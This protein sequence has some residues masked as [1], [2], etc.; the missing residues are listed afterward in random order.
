MTLPGLSYFNVLTHRGSIPGLDGLRGIAILL[1]LVRH[2]TVAATG[3]H[4]TFDGW[5]TWNPLT[6]LLNGWV[7]VD[8][9]FVLS[10]FLITHHLLANWPERV[11]VG[12]F[13]RYWLK[14][15][16]RTFPAYYATLFVVA[17]G[18][19]PFYE[20]TARDFWAELVSHV[21]FLQDYTGSNFVVAFWSLGVEE[22]FYLVAPFVL[23]LIAA[24]PDRRSRIA[25]A[26]GLVVL[27]L[28]CRVVVHAAS[29]P[30]ETYAAYFWSV[31]APFHLA[32]DGLWVGG[33]CAWLHHHGVTQHAQWRKRIR[34]LTWFALIILL[35]LVG[36]LP[37]MA[38]AVLPLTTFALLLI[39]LA[40][41]LLVLRV[42]I[43]D[44]AR[45]A[46]LASPVL[47]FFSN[48][49]YSLYLVHMPCIPAA[50]WI[51][52]QLIDA[53]GVAQSCAFVFAFVVFSVA[54][55]LLLHWTVE[56]PFLRLKDSLRMKSA[57]A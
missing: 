4:E 38:T 29:H 36:W 27:P 23:M 26:V 49:S 55:A 7:G 51:S 47:R 53:D 45:G 2:G 34:Q 10:G 43:S 31:R 11:S 6:P 57:A 9:F 46:C 1:V 30:V 16:L 21:L 14:R 22:K 33:V 54:A 17:F 12:F 37:L 5:L 56:K 41:G 18:L 24:L 3:Q 40:F 32:L 42:L 13:G 48:I 44:G 20:H 19:F 25:V 50:L 28:L 15:V 35:I 8:L 39:P 52:R